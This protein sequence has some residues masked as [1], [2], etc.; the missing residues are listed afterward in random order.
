MHRVVY[1]ELTGGCN[2]LLTLDDMLQ[3]ACL[4]INDDDTNRFADLKEQAVEEIDWKTDKARWTKVMSSSQF[5]ELYGSLKNK[6]KL[7]ERGFRDLP[8]VG[9]AL[10]PLFGKIGPTL[11]F[12]GV[13]AAAY[14][15]FLVN[16]M[17]GGFILADGLGLGDRPGDRWPR[18]FTIMVLLTGMCVGLYCILFL[19]SQSPVTLIVTAQAVTVLASPLVAGSLLW[20]TSRK[21]I[22]GENVNGPVALTLGLIGLVLL[23]AMSTNLAITRVLPAVSNAIGI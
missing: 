3:F 7:V 2:N 23:L 13:F 5:E 17:I 12:L 19:E 22:M 10:Q 8:E 16:S 4:V 15:S 1:V 20:L 6:P 21:D 18:I 14:S 11:F 9:T